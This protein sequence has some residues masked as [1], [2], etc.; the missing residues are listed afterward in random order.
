MGTTGKA[1]TT[2]E[3]TPEEKKARLAELKEDRRALTAEIKD[4]VIKYFSADGTFTGSETQM[5]E[6]DRLTQRRAD[7]DY[8]RSNL[9]GPMSEEKYNATEG[10]VTDLNANEVATARKDLMKDREIFDAVYKAS[11]G[12]K[13]DD[14]TLDTEVDQI[15]NANPNKV[16]NTFNDTRKMLRQKY[17]DTITLYRAGTSATDKATQNYTSTRAN[18]EDYARQYGTRVSAVKVPV[19]DV[20]LVNVSRDG[21]YEEF[22]VLKKRK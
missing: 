21:K 10:K 22:V 3:L 9:L 7:L 4:F 19:E 14:T 20:L 6:W 11:V 5:N 15:Y 18:A 17:G 13:F 2:K 1:S 12:V 16:Y 8:E